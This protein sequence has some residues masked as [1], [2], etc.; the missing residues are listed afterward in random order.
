MPTPPSWLPS[1]AQ[2]EWWTTGPELHRLGLLTVLDLV[3][4]GAY[5][6]AYHHWRTASEMLAR[7]AEKDPSTSGLLVKRADG[8]DGPNPLVGIDGPLTIWF[9]LPGISGCRRPRVPG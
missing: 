2:D 9:R 8:N 6:Q 5:C 4:F 3:T 7:M 1:S